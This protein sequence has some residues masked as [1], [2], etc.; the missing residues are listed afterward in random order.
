MVSEHARQIIVNFM[1]ACGSGTRHDKDS[2][3]EPL[4]PEAPDIPGLSLSLDRV[5]AILRRQ[6]WVGSKAHRCDEGADAG[7][8]NLGS[9]RR[10]ADANMFKT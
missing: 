2:D 10:K 5:H 4:K 7:S 9:P 1:S 6:L 3:E 8:Y